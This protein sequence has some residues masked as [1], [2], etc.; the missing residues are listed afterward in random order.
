MERPQLSR[1]NQPENAHYKRQHEKT[2]RIKWR[3]L[4]KLW[5]KNKIPRGRRPLGHVHNII[6]HG[7]LHDEKTPAEGVR[8]KIAQKNQ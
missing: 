4:Q 6:Q 2:H 3:R 7:S 5:L 1:I 8:P